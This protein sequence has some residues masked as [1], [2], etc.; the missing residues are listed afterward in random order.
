MVWPAFESPSPASLAAERSVSG[1]TAF[2][3]R[4]K[5]LIPLNG[6]MAEWL[7]AHAWKLNLHARADA[8]QIPPT[9][10]RFN[11]FR[12]IDVRR[13]VPVNDD[14]APGF[15]GVCD[16]VLTQRGFRLPRTHINQ[17]R[18]V[19]S[20]RARMRIDTRSASQPALENPPSRLSATTIRSSIRRRIC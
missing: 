14:V 8:Y 3:G 11:D 18:V 17:H 19:R 6:E 13:R 20:E 15:R 5:L 2:G 4:C 9:Q 12:N 7:K 10:F 1:W 16:T